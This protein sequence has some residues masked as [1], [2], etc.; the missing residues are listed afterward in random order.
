MNHDTCKLINYKTLKI[1][2]IEHAAFE[3]IHQFLEFEK[4]IVYIIA[5][6]RSDLEYPLEYDGG[7]LFCISKET[8][9][10]LWQEKH[11]GYTEIWKENNRDDVVM[12]FH[13]SGYKVIL[14][15]ATGNI[16]NTIFVK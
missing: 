16:L 12:A 2:N 4:F 10:I 13:F 11:K 6:M 5:A 15:L 7:N 3:R 1:G 9:K 8:I 14:D